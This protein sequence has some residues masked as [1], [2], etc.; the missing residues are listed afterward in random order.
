MCDIALVL[1][2]HLFIEKIKTRET[3]YINKHI[4]NMLQQLWGKKSNIMSLLTFDIVYCQ[5]R[6]E[7]Q[8]ICLKKKKNYK[9]SC[10]ITFHN[11][12]QN[13]IPST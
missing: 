11:T 13:Y 12:L 1:I 3:Q 7:N 5:G 2:S 9:N 10:M 8:E 6:C 4:T